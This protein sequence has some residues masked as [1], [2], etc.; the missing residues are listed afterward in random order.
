MI[1]RNEIW[2]ALRVLLR[3]NPAKLE[4]VDA[5]Q[6]ERIRLWLLVIL[7]YIL[8]WRFDPLHTWIKWCLYVFATVS[9]WRQKK[10]GERGV[11]VYACVCAK[12]ISIWML[13]HLTLP[14]AYKNALSPPSLPFSNVHFS[15]VLLP[16]FSFDISLCSLSFYFAFFGTHC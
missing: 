7:Q 12:C 15:F 6:Y 9:L 11:W 14:G 1:G 10:D 5:A 16:F 3:A 8:Q 13:S 4:A 2:I